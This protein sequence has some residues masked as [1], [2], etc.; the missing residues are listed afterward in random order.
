MPCQSKQSV[1]KKMA[2]W[3]CT[4]LLNNE[5]LKL[6]LCAFNDINLL[7]PFA[8][9]TLLGRWSF[10]FPSN[11]I[12]SKTV[13]INLAFA[14]TFYKEYSINF[15]MVYSL[16]DSVLVVL[17]LLRIK[18]CGIISVSIIE[19]FNF[20]VTERVTFKCGTTFWP[21]FNCKISFWPVKTT[22]QSIF[23]D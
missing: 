13:I 22:F 19:I 23:V 3:K 14:R 10:H 15:L 9:R 18:V 4:L 11:S 5:L 2:L 12:I 6:R 7:N 17:N 8:P 16:I 20:S 1:H 21:N